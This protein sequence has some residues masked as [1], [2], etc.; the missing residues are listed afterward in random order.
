MRSNPFDEVHFFIILLNLLNFIK[1]IK[2]LI[3]NPETVV[4]V[5]ADHGS[6][7]TTAVP[8]RSR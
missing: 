3:P 2:F 7:P 6:C 4:A 8:V 5:A 1:F